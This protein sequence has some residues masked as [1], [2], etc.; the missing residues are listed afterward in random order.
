MGM[1]SHTLWL[2]APDH[3]RRQRRPLAPLVRDGLR[4]VAPVAATAVVVAALAAPATSGFDGLPRWSQD[5]VSAAPDSAPTVA[6]GTADGAKGR[7]TVRIDRRPPRLATAAVPSPPGRALALP[8]AARAHDPAAHR[9][10]VGPPAKRHAAPGHA[11]GVAAPDSAAPAAAATAEP[12]APGAPAA[13]QPA[14]ASPAAGPATPARSGSPSQDKPVKPAKASPR[15]AS[16]SPDG[17]A[18]ASGETFV[19]ASSAPAP[20]TGKDTGSGRTK[21]PGNGREPGKAEDRDKAKR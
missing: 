8:A 6:D 19:G 16:P 17:S 5:A 2:P 13:A 21:E 11:D 1:A 3:E 18:A 10:V 14:A 15:S 20:S 9:R 4:I 12:A 7:V